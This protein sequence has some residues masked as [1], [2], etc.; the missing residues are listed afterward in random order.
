[1]AKRPSPSSFA[2]TRGGR[3]RIARKAMGW[4]QA[5][6]GEAIG[7]TREA[8]SQYEKGSVETISPEICRLLVSRLG[9]EPSDVTEDLAMFEQYE[10]LPGVS[11]QARW[12]ARRWDSLPESLRTWI[13]HMVEGWEHLK[14]RH[15]AMMQMLANPHGRNEILKLRDLTQKQQDDS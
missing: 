2:T 7:V 5:E 15:P 10:Q 12:I 14:T 6:L 11:P 1:M 4:S 9:L 3:I 8:V 13:V